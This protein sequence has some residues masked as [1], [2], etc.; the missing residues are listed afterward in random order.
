MRPEANVKS[1]PLHTNPTTISIQT[2]IAATNNRHHATPRE[3]I[4]ILQHRSHTQRRRRLHN[5]PRMLQQQPHTRDNRPLPHQ[6]GIINHLKEIIQNH[7]NGKPPGN[8]IRDRHSGIR[9]DHPPL[10]PRTRHRR[11]TS[12]LHTDHLNPRQQRLHHKPHTGRHRTP[13]QRDQNNIE[14]RP[15]TRQLQTNGRRTLT[16]LKIQRILDQPHTTPLR[17]LHRPLAGHLE[18]TLHHLQLRTQRTNPIKLHR[19]RPTR[20]HH[21]HIQTTAKTRPTER[22]TQIPGTGTHRRRPH[23]PLIS[24]QA[25]HNLRTPALETADRVR[26]LQLDAHRAAKT[27]AQRVALV[28]RRVEEHRIDQLASGAN[29]VKMKAC[30]EHGPRIYHSRRPSLGFLLGRVGVAHAIAV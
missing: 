3:P 19:R 27:A 5:Q 10:T 17:K 2:D 8:T 22:L 7:R 6:D 30:L 28:Q 21:R 16:R 23:P 29:P 14:R 9:G 13:T 12:R 25:R 11:R 26:R 1:S 18:I 24:Q 4:T 15:P 20:S